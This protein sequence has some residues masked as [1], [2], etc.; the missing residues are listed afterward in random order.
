M[1]PF[2]RFTRA[3]CFAAA[4][5]A[6]VSLLAVSSHMRAFPEFSPFDEATHVDYVFSISS[7]ELPSRGTPYDERVL[8]EWSCRGTWYE[9]STIPACGAASYDY[10]VYPALGIQRNQTGPLYYSVVA[11]AS[12]PAATLLGSSPVGAARLTGAGFLFLTIVLTALAAQQLGASLPIAWAVAGLIPLGMPLVLHAT[13]TVNSD[14]GALLIGALILPPA[15]APD[16]TG[17]RWWLAAIA[18]AVIAALTKQS[19]L[20]PIGALAVAIVAR[21]LSGESTL[22]NKQRAVIAAGS[23]CAAGAATQGVWAAVVSQRTLDGYVSP[24]GMGNTIATA[25]NPFGEALSGMLANL[26]PTH[27]GFISAALATPFQP[28]TQAALTFVFLA[29]LGAALTAGNPVARSLAWGVI[30]GCVGSVLLLQSYRAIGSA[31]FFPVPV[32]RYAIGLIPPS[33]VLVAVFFDS[34]R[35]LRVLGWVL[36]ALSAA[37]GIASLHP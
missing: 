11:L 36:V 4:V 21:S 23:V 5:M 35:E 19:A 22:H 7:F 13:S 37:A 6:V 18:L 31:R 32:S 24:I 30:T 34:R 12:Q 33:L 2:L 14:A 16:P 3:D 1:P 8:S 9:N 15:L 25:G 27:S 29:S 10:S 28:T 26:P 20:F 17:R